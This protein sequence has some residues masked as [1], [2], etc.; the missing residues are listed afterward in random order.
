MGE[1][2]EEKAGADAGGRD[3]GLWVSTEVLARMVAKFTF[4][5]QL[6]FPTWTRGMKEGV[7]RDYARSTGARQGYSWQV[8]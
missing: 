8:R 2:P 7:I 4:T 3:K 1:N 5:V 6:S